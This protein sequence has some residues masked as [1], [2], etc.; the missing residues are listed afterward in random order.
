MLCLSNI[1]GDAGYYSLLALAAC[2]KHFIKKVDRA[3]SVA[4]AKCGEPD[5]RRAT[6]LAEQHH[7]IRPRGAAVSDHARELS[8]RRVSNFRR[9][10]DREDMEPGAVGWPGVKAAQAALCRIL[11]GT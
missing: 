8:S 7:K 11:S 5:L 1:S 2:N 9:Q 6:I 10:P 3:I 4:T